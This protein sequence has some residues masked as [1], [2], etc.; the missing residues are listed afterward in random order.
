M[1]GM[2]NTSFPHHVFLLC[3]THPITAEMT[4]DAFGTRRAP[5]TDF[6]KNLLQQYTDGGQIL[7]V[8]YT[9]KGIKNSFHERTATLQSRLHSFLSHRSSFRMPTMLE[10]ARSNSS[11][12]PANTLA[13]LVGCG[14]HPSLPFRAQ[15]CSPGTTVSSVRLTG[16]TLASCTRAR[17]RRSC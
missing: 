17:R 5:L 7:K 3:V 10:P 6:I 13:T 1:F 12:T 8:R 15:P 16:R 2:Y 11:L 14:S 4:D 9:D